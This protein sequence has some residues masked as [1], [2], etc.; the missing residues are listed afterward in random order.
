MTSA[1]PFPLPRPQPNPSATDPGRSCFAARPSA[2]AT[3]ARPTRPVSKTSHRPTRTADQ[4]KCP[5]PTKGDPWWR[6]RMVE[7]PQ[8][9][10]RPPSEWVA[11]RGRGFPAAPTSGRKPGVELQAGETPAT[12]RRPRGRSLSGRSRR[13][14]H[15][16]PSRPTQRRRPGD[17]GQR[18]CQHAAPPVEGPLA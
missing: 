15:E 3:L 13:H 1:T 10:R 6:G 7:P 11:A 12:R 14:A 17:P 16:P 5:P 18:T 8:K 2:P 4:T 9:A